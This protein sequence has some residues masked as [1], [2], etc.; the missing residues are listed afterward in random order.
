ME[1]TYII[2]IEH[3]NN[4]KRFNV[5]SFD[6]ILDINSLWN[7]KENANGINIYIP[8]KDANM[9]LL[10]VPINTYNANAESNIIKEALTDASW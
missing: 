2:P 3:V 6:N 1:K 5:L 4:K 10:A 8:N 7:K 9:E